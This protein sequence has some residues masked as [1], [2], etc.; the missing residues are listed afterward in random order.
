MLTKNRQTRKNFTTETRQFIQVYIY[1]TLQKSHEIRNII[2]LL[3][4]IT[5]IYLYSL[6]I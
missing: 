1:N 5:I 2:S 6:R 3:Q 4:Y